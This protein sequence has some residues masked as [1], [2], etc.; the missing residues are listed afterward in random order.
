MKSKPFRSHGSILEVPSSRF[1][2]SELR[3][4][5]DPARMNAMTSWEHLQ[6]TGNIG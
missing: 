2:D 5:A 1:Y 4:K 3:V 6:K